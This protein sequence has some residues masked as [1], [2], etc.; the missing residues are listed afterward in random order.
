MSILIVD[1]EPDIAVVLKRILMTDGFRVDSYT[2][3]H[4]A[5]SNFRAGLYDL[6][7]LDF[8]M[9]DMNGFMLYEM[10][11]KKIIDDD[12]GNSLKVLFL[13]GDSHHYADHRDRFPDVPEARFLH[14]PISM[15]NLVREV[16]SIL[17]LI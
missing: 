14:K 8:K 13:S 10:M 17:E 4:A 2:D 3:P 12:N 16:K 9:N 6:V 1:D 5:L 15:Q 7:I 11:K